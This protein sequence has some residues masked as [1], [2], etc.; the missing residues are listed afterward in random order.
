LM[1]QAQQVQQ[2]VQKRFKAVKQQAQQQAVETQKIA[3]SAAW[4]LFGTALTSLAASAIA[5]V[6]AV[7][8]LSTL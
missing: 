6:M 1:H 8:S 7:N 3:A 4:W 5:G 2:E